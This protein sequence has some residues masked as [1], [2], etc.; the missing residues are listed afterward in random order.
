[1]A[2]IRLEPVTLDGF[3][4]DYIL[5]AGDTV[6]VLFLAREILGEG[7]ILTGM[8]VSSTSVFSTAQDAALLPDQKA[9]VF[10]IT[11]TTSREIFTVGINVTTNDGQTFNF[12]IGLQVDSP[13]VKTGLPNPVPL[14]IGPTGASG[15]TGP[16]GDA[17][18]PTGSTG[19]TGSA[20]TGVTGPTGQSGG[21]GNTG[22]TGV[23]GF[24]GPTG[25]TGA[26]GASLTGP[27]G[28]SGTAGSA[29]PTGPSGASGP[30]GSVGASGPTGPTGQSGSAGISGATGPTGPAGGGGGVSGGTGA[31]GPT[32]PSGAVATGSTGASGATGATGTAGNT[33]NTGPTGA[34][35]SGGSS[36]APGATGPTGPSGATGSAGTTGTVG[37]TGPT[38]AS[39]PTGTNG[40]ASTVTGPTGPLGTGPTGPSGTVGSTGPTG[41]TGAAGTGATGPTGTFGMPMSLSYAVGTGTTFSIP[42]GL[43]GAAG[44][45]SGKLWDTSESAWNSATGIFTAPATGPYLF[46]GSVYLAAATC[47]ELDIQLNKNGSF[48]LPMGGL[49]SNTT[50]AIGSVCFGSMVIELNAGDTI[51]VG[52]QQI[53]GGAAAIVTNGGNIAYTTFSV[54]QLSGGANGPTGPSGGPTGATGA[55]GHTGANGTNGSAGAT[56]AA[57]PSTLSANMA[58]SGHFKDSG[59]G[60]IINWGSFSATGS[61]TTAA[62]FDQAFSSACFSAVITI[63]GAS[64]GTN[65]LLSVSAV[66]TTQITVSNAGATARTVFYFAIGA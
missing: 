2:Y 55:T 46:C 22:P 10:Y 21:A 54:T 12:T 14:I 29:G 63:D 60:F 20:G 31:T 57:G 41:Q 7:V 38:G 49:F 25:Q 9:A 17:G 65:S 13:V 61:T 4:G 51:S 56:G 18:G 39:G 52:I 30:S 62:N 42:N 19:P 44:I 16:G 48:Y 5:G 47:T 37:A 45:F 59:T 40:A 53:S 32:G 27:T 58:A 43:T 1:M 50:T 26:G 36:G 64:T 6:K 11:S 3:L 34:Q 33:G 24:T 66:S 28:A 15:A 35:G 23:G 8:S